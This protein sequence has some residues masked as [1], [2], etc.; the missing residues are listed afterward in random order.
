[1]SISTSHKTQPTESST[2]LGWFLY[3]GGL[4]SGKLTKQVLSFVG[5]LM[6]A[7]AKSSPASNETHASKQTITESKEWTMTEIEQIPAIQRKK[8]QL[9]VEGSERCWCLVRKT[10]S[11]DPNVPN[12]IKIILPDDFDP[13]NLDDCLWLAK[14]LPL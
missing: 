6:D 5:E 2:A 12:E 8:K 9:T 13:K 7:P 11:Q 3:Y 4:L 1:M 10:H 14:Q